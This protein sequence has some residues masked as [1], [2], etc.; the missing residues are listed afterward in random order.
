M[1][2]RS[3]KETTRRGAYHDFIGFE[4]S[5]SV[6]E[7]AF[8]DTYC[9]DL[10]SVFASVDLAIGSYRHAVSSVIPRTTKVAWHMKRKEIQN[11]H[12]NEVRSQFV[13]NVSHSEYRKRLGKS[14]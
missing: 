12:P 13:Y 9:I 8:A 7:R 1:S 6:L 5:K 2:I 3:Q 4:V 10:S 14:L 11:S